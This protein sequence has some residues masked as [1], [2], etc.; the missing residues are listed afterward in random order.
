M[1]AKNCV[2]I[3]FILFNLSL[4]IKI[5]RFWVSTHIR[6]QTSH[7]IYLYKSVFLLFYSAL[8]TGIFLKCAAGASCYCIILNLFRH[9]QM[10]H[11]NGLPWR[12]K[13]L[14][15]SDESTFQLCTQYQKYDAHLCE[16]NGCSAALYE[17]RCVSLLSKVKESSN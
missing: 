7:F 17:H 8:D 16:H 5:H 10:W 14:P 9:G 4:C 1:T 6:T 13:W 15:V 12:E 2:L 3:I 11:S